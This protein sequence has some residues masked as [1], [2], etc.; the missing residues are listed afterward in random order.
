MDKYR[1]DSH[2]LI[3]HPDR[4]NK[5]L[6]GENIY[7]LYM[8]ISLY[9]GCNHRCIFCGVDYLGHKAAVLDK[10]YLKKFITQAAQ[11]GVKSFMY[12]G[13][14]EPLLHKNFTEIVSW[15]KKK[16]ID[17]AV[18]SNGV[19]FTEEKA[20]ECLGNLSWFRVS[21]DA[22]TAETY[23]KIRKTKAKDFDVVL[24]NISNAVKIRNKNKY[25]CTIGAQLII[26]P[27]NINEMG[28]LAKK[29]KSIGTDYLIIKPYSQHPLSKN[30]LGKL[31]DYSKVLHKKDE[32]KKYSSKNFNIIFRS[33]AMEKINSKVN[34]QQC[35]GLSFSAYLLENGDLFPC[36]EV[37]GSK[38]YVY[39][40][41]YRESF[42][43]IWQGM[44]RK[45]VMEQL[46]RNFATINSCERQSRL[47]EMNE[48]LWNLKNPPRH[49]NF[50]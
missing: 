45:K 29:L 40:N 42:K 43:G 10:S 18:T 47:E 41:I 6:Q 25:N 39:G 4:V 31:I 21:L 17:V 14:G 44:R 50:I 26:L 19:M 38:K 30:R 7:P 3:Y 5:W 9:G 24:N 37:L 34:Y 1:I 36:I 22:G 48:Y 27:Q 35:Y 2:K 8:E 12:A 28:I 16:G 15:T 46:N 11:K 23:A 32:L 13:T 33:N 49:V 20:E